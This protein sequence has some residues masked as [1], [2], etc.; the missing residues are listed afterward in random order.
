LLRCCTLLAGV[1][2]PVLSLQ[3]GLTSKPSYAPPYARSWRVCLL[4]HLRCTG[5]T[6]L[7]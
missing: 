5:L 6:S 4:M 1:D 2:E 3:Q 7:V